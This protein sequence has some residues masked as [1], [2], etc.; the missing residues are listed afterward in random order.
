MSLI[1]ICLA[2]PEMTI[3]VLVPGSYR[4]QYRGMQA[5]ALAR[6]Q[7]VFVMVAIN[8]DCLLPEGYGYDVG[9]TM[10]R[11]WYLKL[12][13][14]GLTTTF[15]CFVFAVAHEMEFWLSSPDN[16]DDLMEAIKSHFA[17]RSNKVLEYDINTERFTLADY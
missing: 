17:N 3:S 8:R 5:F 12:L 14:F 10:P 6:T 16:Q 13:S 7:G 4:N 9:Y 1:I 15:N 11:D 2:P